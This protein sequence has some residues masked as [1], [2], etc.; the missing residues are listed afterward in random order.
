MMD[1]WMNSTGHRANILAPDFTEIGIGV[2]DQGT[3]L[4][5]QAFGRP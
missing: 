4:W 3:T 1:L 5:V 2:D